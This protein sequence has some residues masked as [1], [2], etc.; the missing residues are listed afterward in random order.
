MNYWLI[1]SEPDVFSISALATCKNQTTHWDGVRNY[2]AR[3]YL[4]DMMKTGDR[5]FF[6]H[7]SC[8]PAGIAGICE[9]VREGYP[10]HSAFDTASEYHDPKSSPS[11]PAWFMVDIKLVKQF[12]RLITLDALRANP[13]LKE[14]KLLARGNRLSVLPVTK[15]EWTAVCA[16]AT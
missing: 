12:P 11:A 4:R 1:K 16:M 13:A 5:V 14:M 6:Y 9:V 10:D 3:N 7:S 8:D 2:Q 15:A